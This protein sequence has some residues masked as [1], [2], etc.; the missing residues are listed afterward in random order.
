MRWPWSADGPN[1]ELTTPLADLDPATLEVISLEPDEGH[2]PRGSAEHDARHE[3]H[4]ARSG[5]D[6]TGTAGIWRALEHS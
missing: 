6:P 1:E 3:V 5:G 4:Y 2:R